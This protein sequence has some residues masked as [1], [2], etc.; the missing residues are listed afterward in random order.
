VKLRPSIYSTAIL[1]AALGASASAQLHLIAGSPNPK[2]SETYEA[3]LLRVEPDG[4]TKQL[5]ELVALNVATERISISYDWRK[6]IIDAYEDGGTISVLD[7]DTA[8]IVK[9]CR[10]QR[11][12]GIG[13][14]VSWLT[15]SP[16]LGP[17]YEGQSFALPPKIPVVLAMTL[18]PAVACA[19]SFV[20]VDA[21]DV[22]YAVTEGHAGV[23]NVVYPEWLLLGMPPLP[24]GGRIFEWIGKRIEF[25]YD[26]PVAIR[27]GIGPYATMVVNDSRVL[28]LMFNT[29]EG[30]RRTAVFRK[31][32]RTWRL[33]PAPEFTMIRGFG[34]YLG[35]IEIERQ[36]SESQVS[37]GNADWREGRSQMGPDLRSMFRQF[38]LSG[39]VHGIFPGR[40]AVY[41]VEL[42]RVYS[43]VTNQADSE[44]LL[45]D[46][47]IVYY[48]VATRIYSA[49]IEGRGLGAPKLI[50]DSPDINDA[51]WAFF[52]R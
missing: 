28:V 7:F 12:P 9:K 40:L 2:G 46:K 34:R 41:D 43:I 36:T 39:E 1:L 51:H 11:M 13:G 42:D 6:A 32:D 25:D 24:G 3:A 52:K 48:R 4:S 29:Q 8:A 14:I 50:A 38:F 30:R 27:C 47:N 21:S 5:S 45:V 17:A 18:N 20:T 37:A 15:N 33:L 31:T 23:A 49:A 44:V 16:T 19:K 22:R 26:V 35:I 10:G